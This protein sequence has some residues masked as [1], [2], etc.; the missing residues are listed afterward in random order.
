MRLKKL[1]QLI[2][3][4]KDQQNFALIKRG[5]LQLGFCAENGIQMVLSNSTTGEDR[6]IVHVVEV[7][8]LLKNPIKQRFGV[9][10]VPQ[11]RETE[12][13]FGTHEGRM[14]L[15]NQANFT[16]LVV[17]H[18]VRGQTYENMDSVQSELKY[19]LSPLSP[20]CCTEKGIKV[21]LSTKKHV[22]FIISKG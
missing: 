4:I 1:S 17:V 15:A 3:V 9:F 7:L 18:L 11:G 20:S 6:F 19:A 8:K 10:V 21:I 12:W 16:R 22:L 14:S 5:L 13:L 2:D